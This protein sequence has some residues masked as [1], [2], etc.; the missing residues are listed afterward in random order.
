MLALLVA[1]L[2]AQALG[3]IHRG[4]HGADGPLAAAAGLHAPAAEAPGLYDLFGS[5][6]EPTDCRL[7]DGITHS[8]CTPPA[9]PV[10]SPAPPAAFLI[11]SHG[12]FVARWSALFEARGPPP[13]R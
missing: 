9:L 12:E 13:A 11:A 6:E 5:H 2:L 8:A 4:L 3:W 1:F 7:F 10:F